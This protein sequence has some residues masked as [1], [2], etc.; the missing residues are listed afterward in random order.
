MSRLFFPLSRVPQILRGWSPDLADRIRRATPPLSFWRHY[1]YS[2]SLLQK[3]GGTTLAKVDHFPNRDRPDDTSISPETV[4]H[5]PQ[6]SLP[7]INERKPKWRRGPAYICT[8]PASSLLRCEHEECMTVPDD[9]HRRRSI[10]ALP[11]IIP[12]ECVCLPPDRLRPRLWPR[13]SSPCGPRRGVR[14]RRRLHH[15]HRRVLARAV[16]VIVLLDSVRIPR[17]VRWRE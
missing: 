16:R 14:T 9:T 17:C 4:A 6:V 7:G 13:I 11:Q 8:I 2:T 1:I 10:T 5:V 3:G 12:P 15:H